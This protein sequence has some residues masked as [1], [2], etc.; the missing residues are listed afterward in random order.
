MSAS[1]RDWPRNQRL[2]HA[3]DAA[4]HE[5]HSVHRSP[6]RAALRFRDFTYRTQTSCVVSRIGQGGVPRGTL[7]Y[8]RCREDGPV[9]SRPNAVGSA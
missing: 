8:R 1:C 2:T 3:L 7:G 4:I 9:L 6:G 5:A